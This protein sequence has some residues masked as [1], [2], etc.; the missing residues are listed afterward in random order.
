MYNLNFRNELG[1]K[2]GASVCSEIH[3]LVEIEIALCFEN[4]SMNAEIHTAFDEQE[5]FWA[6]V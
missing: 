5:Y 1:E 2:T 3:F 6:A 4:S